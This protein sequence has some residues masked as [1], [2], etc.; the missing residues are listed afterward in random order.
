MLKLPVWI[1]VD[2]GMYCSLD[3]CCT[4]R[5]AVL[6]QPR[7][8][9]DAAFS[10]ATDVEQI[11]CTSKAQKNQIR[12]T[13][14]PALGY[15]PEKIRR[16]NEM[17]LYHWVNQQSIHS[18]VPIPGGVQSHGDVALRN[19]VSGHSGVGWD[20]TWGSEGSFPTSTSLMTPHVSC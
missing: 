11:R 3:E 16:K 15:E 10:F 13:G 8:Q 5:R 6:T 9:A 2:D 12:T 20:W 19:V 7:G 4:R 17:S 1:I 18:G 14:N